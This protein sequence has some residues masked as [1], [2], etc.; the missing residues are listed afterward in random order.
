MTRRAFVVLSVLVAAGLVF[1]EWQPVAGDRG[2]ADL[3]V[4]EQSAA[5]TVRE[6]SSPGVEVTP[7]DAEGEVFSQ[8]SLPGDVRASIKEGRPEI[9]KVSVLLAIP[10]GAS[11]SARA[12]VLDAKVLAVSNVYPQQPPLLDGQEPGPLVIERGFYSQ[13][14]AYPGRDMSVIET[15]VWRDLHVVNIQVY[16][17]QVNPARG[18]ITVASKIRLEVDYSGGVYPAT[19][20]DWMIP[21]YGS[22]IDNF[23]QVGLRPE[24]D[25]TAGIRYLVFSHTDYSSN[26]WLTDSL[27][28]WVK[29]RGYDVRMI[30]KSSFTAAEI[31]DSVRAEYNS[32]SPALLH[33]VLL[34]GEY[35]QVPTGSYSS[36]PKSDYY[37]SDIEP[38]P[39][40]DKY[41]ELGIA[42]LSPSSTGDLENQIKKILKYQKAPPATNDWLTKLPMVAH[43]QNYPGKYSGCIRGI[44][45][46]P[47]P[48]YDYDCDTIMGQYRN[49]TAVTNAVESGAGI[50]I[51]RGH[52]NET[53]WTGWCG[54]D[55]SNSNVDALSNG[56]LT[57]VTYHFACRSGDIATG[58]CHSEKWMRKY[59]GGAVSALAATQNS[60]TYPNH[61]QC[62]TVVRATA[63]TWTIT[64]TGVR[65][66]LGP[67]F[68]VS[69]VMGY[70]DAYL[71]K[72]WPSSP[73]Y[74]NIYM[75][76][77][78]GDPSMPVWSGGMPQHPTVTYPDSIPTGPYDLNVTVRVGSN[79]VEGALVCAWKDTDFYVSERTDAG[80]N[81][82]LA[83]NAGT[84]GE[85]LI[86]V[87]EG[88]VRH[89]VGGAAHTPI[90]PHEGTTMAG[91]GGTPQPNMVYLSN[92]VDDSGG[93]G[94][95]RFDPGETADIIVTV[96]NTGNAEAEN[97]TGLLASGNALFV[98]SDP[99]SSFGTVPA[100][101]TVTNDADRFTATADAAIP[102]GTTVP[103]TLHL[104][105]DNRD[106]DWTHVFTLQVG[107]PPMPAQYVIT[108]D[109][110]T[111]SLSV[112]GIG[113]IGYDEPPS[114][115]GT[116]FIVPKTGSNTL[117]FGSVMAGNSASY[118]VDHFYDQ[119]ASSG[120]HHDWQMT[121]SFRLVLPAAP[122]DEHW[123]NTMDDGGH[124]SAKGLEVVQN[125][126]MNADGG[127]Y[128]DWAIVTFDFENGGGSDINDLYVGM[129]GDFD[130]EP[131]A[132][133]NEVSSNTSRRAVR[134]Q[135]QS[136]ANPTAGL[137]LLHPTTHANLAAID[138]D[139]YIYPDSC[140]TDDQKL[141]MLNGGIGM[142]QSN[143]PYDWSIVASAGPFDLA[144][145]EQQRV[146]F[147]VVGATSEGAW[148]AAVD[149][150]QS[151]YDANLL[152]ITE[153]E[154]PRIA[155]VERPFFLSPNPFSRG[156]FVHYFSRLPGRVELSAFDA[157]G[158]VVDRVAFDTES[159]AGRYFWQ[160]KGLAHGIYFLKVKTPGQESV[161]KVLLME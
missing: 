29:K 74:W 66:Y 57:P 71:A 124:S 128:D 2:S 44:Y 159:G 10:N 153:G 35:N 118:L 156:T 158:R 110:G 5:R 60:F 120:T 58:T 89:S 17:V 37:Y 109:T 87:T 119:P 26:A 78:L 93:N 147:A 53:A 101:S 123:R 92:R 32:H 61:G 111:V 63:D 51:Y 96:R 94:N 4:L 131:D 152:G 20:A 9:P 8:L 34:V 46:M 7:V 67:V 154:L 54:S 143:R 65:D 38:W 59:P 50:V 141:R 42:R 64:G 130:V 116:G 102:G 127:A 137:V 136:S 86:T 15:G 103:C 145:G 108:I 72:Y 105:A 41:P 31:K 16:P 69:G 85:V 28:G 98:I 30:A 88:H 82:V 84:N 107:D 134:M 27:L 79:P 12:E 43:R 139:I 49:N 62:S 21:Q 3:T 117:F 146:A 45:N 77:T 161:A 19:V 73:E 138:H 121:D 80:G 52:G 11:V 23:E 36:V 129:A 151:W 47:K 13:D 160:P 122:A 91:G 113:S 97:L 149:S 150:A 70:M 25:Y 157:A 83:V 144:V 112:C 90:L 106:Y 126:Y 81:A 142:A 135:H 140:V 155:T 75:Y 55:W 18:E 33:W 133:L 40:G 14:V 56:D 99:N 68:D 115:L 76:L 39:A 148:N 125:W 95:S 1:A 22:Y 6:L 48:Y 24:T 132:R 114:D 104:H 100:G